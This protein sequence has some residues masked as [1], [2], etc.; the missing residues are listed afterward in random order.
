[1]ARGVSDAVRGAFRP[2]LVGAEVNRLCYGR[3]QCPPPIF[4]WGDAACVLAARD[5]AT[6]QCSIARACGA[7]LFA[8]AV[9]E[10]LVSPCQAGGGG[11]PQDMAAELVRIIANGETSAA[12]ICNAF[13]QVFTPR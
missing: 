10:F 2:F 6:F 12:D 7:D 1:M 9:G 4:E 3:M 13:K 5:I 8:Q 11:L